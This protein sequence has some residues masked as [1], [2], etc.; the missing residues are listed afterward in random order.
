MSL[1]SMSSLKYID[2]FVERPWKGSI[3]TM[4]MSTL[5]TKNI[6]LYRSIN[7]CFDCTHKPRWEPD[8]CLDVDSEIRSKMVKVGGGRWQC[9]ECS[10][11]SKTSNVY[12]HVEAK[13]VTEKN[14]YECPLCQRILRG[15]N[16]FNNHLYKSHKKEKSLQF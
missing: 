12:K 4:F 13:H 9:I 1:L 16:A 6:K 3:P 5:Y 14:N 10:Y 15:L 11:I 8:F 2:A 7:L